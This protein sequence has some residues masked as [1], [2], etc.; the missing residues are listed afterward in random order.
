MTDLTTRPADL[1]EHGITIRLTSTRAETAPLCS[2]R[3]CTGTQTGFGR[4]R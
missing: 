2:E 1:A 3:R 4:R